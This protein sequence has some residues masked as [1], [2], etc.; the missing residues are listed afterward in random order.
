MK[1]QPPKPRKLTLNKQR[2]REL[3]NESLTNARGG[4]G[5][6]GNNCVTA[7]DEIFGG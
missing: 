3:S 6:F 1:R 2:L 5:T 4:S 7:P